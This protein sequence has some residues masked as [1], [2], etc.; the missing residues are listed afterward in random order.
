MSSIGAIA[1]NAPAPTQPSSH[2]AQA[3]ESAGPPHTL[4]T[5]A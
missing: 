4:N 2:A 1:G 3:Q 5:I